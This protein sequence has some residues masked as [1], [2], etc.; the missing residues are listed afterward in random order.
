MCK[1]DRRD[2]LLD[3]LGDCALM[4]LAIA[5]IFLTVFIVVSPL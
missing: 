1:S 3:T 2:D 5:G 4:I